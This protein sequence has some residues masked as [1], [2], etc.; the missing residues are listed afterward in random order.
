MSNFLRNCQTDLQSGCN[1]LP[2][3]QQWRSA[4]LSPHPHQHCCC[5]SFLILAILTGVWW[6]LSVVSICISLVAKNIEHFFRCLSTTGDFP[7]EN[8]LFSFVSHF[9]IGLFGSQVSNFLSSL[10]ILNISPLLNL[11]C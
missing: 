10:F 5:L 6:N 7:D 2:S 11:G 9:K 3:H 8:S 1:S 4:P